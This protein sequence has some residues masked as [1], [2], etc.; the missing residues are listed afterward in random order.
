MAKVEDDSQYTLKRGRVDLVVK[1][2][3]YFN[4]DREILA[5]A[6]VCGTEYGSQKLVLLR[7]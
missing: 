4:G 7:L 1:Q 3:E 5:P 6:T 2:C